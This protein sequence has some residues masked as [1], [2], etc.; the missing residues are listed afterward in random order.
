MAALSAIFSPKRIFSHQMLAAFC[1][2]RILI[3][4]MGDIDKEGLGKSRGFVRVTLRG[5]RI[6]RV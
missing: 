4:N 6:C 3:N 2:V 1:K 5:H